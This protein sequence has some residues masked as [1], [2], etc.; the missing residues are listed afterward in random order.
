VER[1]LNVILRQYQP[2]GAVVTNNSVVAAQTGR[3]GVTAFSRPSDGPWLL[4]LAHPVGVKAAG[5]NAIAL[6]TELVDVNSGVSK[7]NAIG[8]TLQTTGPE[9]TVNVNLPGTQFS[10]SCVDLPPAINPVKVAYIKDTDGDGAGDKVF[11]VFT[12]PLAALP[13]SISPIYWNQVG[14]AFANRGKPV[15]SFL[16]GSGNTVVIADLT[17]SPYPKAMTS[18]PDG[19]APTGALPA[20]GV[21]QAQKPLIQDSIGPILV[22]AVIHPFDGSHLQPGGMIN[23]DTIVIDASEG[24]RTASNWDDL[25]VWSKSVDGKCTDFSHSL[26]VIPNG[27]PTQDPASKTFTILVQTGTGTPTPLASDC[28]YLGTKG[29]VT[30][31]KRNAPGEYGVP[32]K[33]NRPPK[34]IELFRGY[35]PVAGITA[36]QPGFMVVTNDPRKGDNYDYSSLD[37]AGSYVTLWIPPVGF[38]PALPFNPV[39][40]P[41]TAPAVGMESAAQQP[42]PK[43]I[44]TIQVVST[45]KYTV[46]I[47]IYDNHGIFTRRMRQAFGFNGELNNRNRISNRGLVSY[48][49]WDL[50]DQT[51]QKAGQGVYVWKAVFRF[52]NGKQEVQYT[53][54]GLIRAAGWN[55]TP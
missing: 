4:R 24:L 50:K 48:L 12:R 42:L 18:I 28:V 53:R 25:L 9:A 23:I 1:I 41:V 27:Q 36:D 20:G 16:T 5:D 21:F 17:A 26:P 47:S 51:G 52:E 3:A 14:P 31:L 34:E 7:T 11:F 43:G 44:S 55:L 32:L 46:E 6:Q 38:N 29:E 30:D 15:L 49:V 13:D 54:T 37:G 10:V 45:G 39:I 8:F 2:S 19:A 35:P 22:S 33:G 40:P